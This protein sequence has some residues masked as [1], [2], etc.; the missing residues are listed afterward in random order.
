MN[1]KKM[2]AERAAKEFKDGMVVNLGFGIPVLAGNYI[3]EGV[4][5]ILQS[6]NGILNFGANAELGEDDPSFCAAGG[7]PVTEVPGCCI[8]NLDT[9]FLIIRGGHVD[10]TILGAL[11]VDQHGNIANWAMPYGENKYGPGMGGAMDLLV[12]AR[13]VIVTTTHT[14]KRGKSKI[15]RKC[16]L[17]LSA[18]GVVNL[19]IT[20]LA[21]MQVTEE[22][23]VLKEVA[24]GVTVEEV[25]AKTEA[26][27]IVPQE[28]G[29]MA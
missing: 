4:N 1:T 15:L 27:L 6:E 29:V 13:K 24:P 7:G 2:I 14:T 17:P 22:G 16:T 11:E 25:I 18:A 23:L 12:G 3:P 28:V 20:E 5:V 8:F 19:I 26:E 21:V 10:M 9:S